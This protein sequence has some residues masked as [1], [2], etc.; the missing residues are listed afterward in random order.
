MNQS[1]N[2]SGLLLISISRAKEKADLAVCNSYKGQLKILYNM[3]YEFEGEEPFTEREFMAVYDLAN[4][5]W[6]CHPSVP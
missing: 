1:M 3:D 2:L 4:R 6:K 5:C